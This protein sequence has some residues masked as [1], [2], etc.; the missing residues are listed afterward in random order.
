MNPL[1]EPPNAVGETGLNTLPSNHPQPVPSAQPDMITR[2][3][4]RSAAATNGTG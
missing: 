3:Q 2:S 4:P 1:S